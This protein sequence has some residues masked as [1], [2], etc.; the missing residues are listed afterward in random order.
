M[1]PLEDELL[2][3]AWTLVGLNSNQATLRRAVSTAYYA[4]F[5]L[6]ISEATLNWNR[7]E[8]R[9]QLGRLFDHGNMRRA[10]EKVCSDFNRTIKNKKLVATQVSRD[11]NDVADS[12][13]KAQQG[14]IEADYVTSRAWTH[15]DAVRIGATRQG[16]DRHFH[17]RAARSPSLPRQ[18]V[19]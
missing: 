19:R 5:H 14:R 17:S 1:N 13:I 16:H 3:L 12:F 9:P 2:Q 6:L 15:D 7:S 4:L 10:S 18:H 11:L 8:H